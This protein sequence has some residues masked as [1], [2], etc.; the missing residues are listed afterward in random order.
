MQPTKTA[1]QSTTIWLNFIPTVITVLTALSNDQLITQH[2][3]AVAAIAT[4]LF[5]LNMLNRFRT[6]SPIKLK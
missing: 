2:P 1:L 6:D 5:V 4:S 3:Q